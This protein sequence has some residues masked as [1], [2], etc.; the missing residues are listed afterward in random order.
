[1]ITITITDNNEIIYGVDYSDREGRTKKEISKEDFAKIQ[2]GLAEYDIETKTV[3]DLPPI[4]PEE[5]EVI[6]PQSLTPRQIRLAML[7]SGISLDSIDTM[8][9]S[10]P[11]KQKPVVKVMWEYSGTYLRDDEILIGFASQL[12]MTSEDIDNLFILWASL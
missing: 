2:N 6:I 5:P 10:L 11:A 3:V 4:E 8:I 1:M 12:D 7:Q 9:E